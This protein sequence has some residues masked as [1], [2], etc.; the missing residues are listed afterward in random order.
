MS[1]QAWRHWTKSFFLT[2]ESA[3]KLIITVND[4][5]L[6]QFVKVETDSKPSTVSTKV[7]YVMLPP[8]QVRFRISSLQVRFRAG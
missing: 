6:R 4:C 1:R 2:S 5:S 8:V 3:I 7:G